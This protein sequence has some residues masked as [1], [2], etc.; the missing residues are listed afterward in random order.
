MRPD[1]IN[2][3]L[4]VADARTVVSICAGHVFPDG[5]IQ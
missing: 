2:G 3:V 1:V 5:P 4:N